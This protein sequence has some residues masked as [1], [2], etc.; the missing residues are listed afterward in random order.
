MTKIDLSQFDNII[1]DFGGVIL[2]INPELT[3]QAFINIYGKKSVDKLFS[4]NLTQKFENGLIDFDEFFLLANNI[5]GKVVS[6]EE[7][8]A[9]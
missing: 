6:K 2:D 8:T 3:K 4:E 7:F 5:A 1:F 9:A